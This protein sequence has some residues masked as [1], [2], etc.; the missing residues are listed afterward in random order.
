MD[1]NPYSFV[2]G[3]DWLELIIWTSH[4]PGFCICQ[5]VFWSAYAWL[6]GQLKQILLF[7]NPFIFAF[8][9]NL[10]LF[11]FANDAVWFCS[12]DL[13]SGKKPVARHLHAIGFQIQPW[14]ILYCQGK[15]LKFALHIY[16]GLLFCYTTNQLIAYEIPIGLRILSFTKSVCDCL[17]IF[18]I[19]P[20]NTKY[21]KFEKL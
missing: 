2:R 18:S 10:W 8:V 19:N 12:T 21:P 11:I 13:G 4:P 17:L 16:E 1:Y 5:K 20:P 6:K 14:H 7:L 3:H 15:V 9:L